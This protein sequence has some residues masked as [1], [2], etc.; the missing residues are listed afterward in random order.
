MNKQIKQVLLPLGIGLTAIGVI[1]GL[2][3]DLFFFSLIVIGITM[4]ILSFVNRK[5]ASG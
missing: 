4:I 2:T 3:I 5:G 1:F